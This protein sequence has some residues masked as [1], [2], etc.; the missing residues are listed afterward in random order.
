MQ[1]TPSEF[2]G[3]DGPC[4]LEMHVVPAARDTLAKEQPQKRSLS[5]DIE[6]SKGPAEGERA[7]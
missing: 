7:A 6:L 4:G 5:G 1:A 3:I 2:F